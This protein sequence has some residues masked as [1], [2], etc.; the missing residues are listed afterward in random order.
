MC[1]RSTHVIVRLTT[2]GQ[3]YRVDDPRGRAQNQPSVSTKPIPCLRA[4][5]AIV[6]FVES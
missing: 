3:R 1:P 6:R 5:A 2:R 4:F